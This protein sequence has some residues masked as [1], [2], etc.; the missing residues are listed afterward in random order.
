[1]DDTFHASFL[2]PAQ[3]HRAVKVP[4]RQGHRLL[5]VGI[6]CRRPSM[7]TTSGYTSSFVVDYLSRMCGDGLTPYSV[8]SCRFATGT[9]I[10]F[11]F[12]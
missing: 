4:G 2:H 5:Q 9:Y 12:F 1:M 10:I 6:Q 8:V 3:R 7:D 11:G